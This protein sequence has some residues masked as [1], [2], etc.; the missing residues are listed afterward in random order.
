[1]KQFGPSPPL[2]TKL[3][4]YFWA[5]F[6]RPL[7]VQIP[8][9]RTPPLILLGRKLWYGTPDRRGPAT[10]KNFF[11]FFF[12][13]KTN[14]FKEW[15]KK[16]IIL[17]MTEKQLGMN[18]RMSVFLWALCSMHKKLGQFFF[19]TYLLPSYTPNVIYNCILSNT[20]WKSSERACILQNRCS[21]KF[22]KFIKKLFWS[23]SLIKL[24]FNKVFCE[25]HDICKN[26]FFTE[27]LQKTT[28]ISSFCFYYHI[29]RLTVAF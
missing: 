10:P 13:F 12:F 18:G 28:F 1:M 22:A 14:L 7:F 3:T 11:F 24:H 29:R 4:P 17:L 19:C 2:P 8:K 25:L 5:I 20:C 15:M 21:K 6:S 16:F 26:A 23:L 27:L 9:T